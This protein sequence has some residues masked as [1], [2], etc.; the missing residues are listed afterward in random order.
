M[1]LNSP[2]IKLRV[3]EL[4]RDEYT[5]NNYWKIP[6]LSDFSLDDL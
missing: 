4:T 3:D 1:I 5:D 6:V 2:G